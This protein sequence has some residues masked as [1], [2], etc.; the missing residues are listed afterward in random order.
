MEPEPGQLKVSPMPKTWILDI[1]RK[2]RLNIYEHE[3][4]YLVQVVEIVVKTFGVA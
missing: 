4:V 2:P 3:P 1:E